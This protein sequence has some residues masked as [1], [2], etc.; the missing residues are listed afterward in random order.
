MIPIQI[1]LI[2]FKTQFK[3]FNCELLDHEPPLT[4]MHF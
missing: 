3:A 4:I 2:D 1:L